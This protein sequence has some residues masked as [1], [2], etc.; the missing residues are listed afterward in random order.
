MLEFVFLQFPQHFPFFFCFLDCDC[1]LFSPIQQKRQQKEQYYNNWCETANVVKSRDLMRQQ[2]PFPICYFLSF[3]KQ[4]EVLRNVMFRHLLSSCQVVVIVVRW[5]LLLLFIVVVVVCCWFIVVVCCWFI[6]VV[7][8]WF[9]VVVVVV[10]CCW[11]IVVV[12]LLLLLCCWFIV[13][14]LLLLYCCCC[15]CELLIV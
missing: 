5:F 2:L 8:C 10:V 7:C 14:V 4:I 12:V 9:I 6:V 15:R 11:F 3:K 13:V 1:V